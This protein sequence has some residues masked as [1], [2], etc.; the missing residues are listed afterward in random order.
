MDD[1]G[2]IM[3]RSAIFKRIAYLIMAI[4]FYFTYLFPINDKK[5][6]LIMTHDESERG[7]LVLH[8]EYFKRRIL[9]LIFKKVTRENYTFKNNKKIC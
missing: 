6:L 4:F 8:I 5:I 9:N 2:I 7:M 1:K 3:D